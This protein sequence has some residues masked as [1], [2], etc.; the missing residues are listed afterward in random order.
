MG[1]GVSMGLMGLLG[2]KYNIVLSSM[3]VILFS[4]GSAYGI[5]VLARFYPL[6]RTM[7]R[8]EA[9]KETLRSVGPTVVIAGLTTVFGLLSFLAMDIAPMRTFGLFT[10]IGIFSTLV[11]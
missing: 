8:E 7:E 1:I 9:L 6:A 2:V 3:P 10:A 11:F 4:V 5:H